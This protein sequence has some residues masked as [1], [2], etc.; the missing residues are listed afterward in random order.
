MASRIM[1][2]IIANHLI[3]RLDIKDIH[4]FHY[5]NFYPDLSKYNG[6]SYEKSHYGHV[7]GHLKGIHF[8]KYYQDHL[9]NEVDDFKLGYFTHLITDAIWLKHIQEPYVRSYLKDKQKRYQMG[10]EDMKA[11]NPLLIKH[12]KVDKV[13][14][15]FK[16]LS[17]SNKDLN[18]YEDF[19]GDLA[20]DFKMS[21]KAFYQFQVYPIEAVISYI[22]F[23]VSYI[24]KLITNPIIERMDFESFLVEVGKSQ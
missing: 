5:G 9:I 10:Y 14:I 4:R 1:H 19:L 12:F 15:D 22:D 17:L 11:L 2:L 18:T 20:N 7:K 3:R 13:H 23:S 24:E 16:A 21:Y 8:E 6:G